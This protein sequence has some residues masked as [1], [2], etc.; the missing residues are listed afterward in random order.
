MF[1]RATDGSDGGS[2]RSDQGGGDNNQRRSFGMTNGHRNNERENQQSHSRG[3][4]NQTN[5]RYDDR[6]NNQSN[7]RST[8]R[9]D[10]R[11]NDRDYRGGNTSSF[12]R[13]NRNDGQP[14]MFEERRS[15]LFSKK[16]DESE[17]SSNRQFSNN[18]TEPRGNFGSRNNNRQSFNARETKQGTE[19]WGSADQ[20]R[21]L[22]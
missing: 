3:R 20:V 11:Q 9:F 14:N 19:D 15:K 4:D 17:G 10:D 7:N 8:N 1:F 12:N 2:V 18:Q 21:T 5:G 22:Y 6:P 16:N 13:D